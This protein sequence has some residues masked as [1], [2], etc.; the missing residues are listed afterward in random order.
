MLGN[1]Y[2]KVYLEYLIFL[3]L[4]FIIFNVVYNTYFQEVFMKYLT[5]AYEGFPSS[6]LWFSLYGAIF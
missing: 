1:S 4:E 6:I 5:A 3:A 2:V